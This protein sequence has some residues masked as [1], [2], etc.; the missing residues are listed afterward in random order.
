[1]ENNKW[2]NSQGI[3]IA[4]KLSENLDRSDL[5]VVDLSAEDTKEL[6]N[7]FSNFQSEFSHRCLSVY[8]D[9]VKVNGKIYD[10]C[11][12]CGDTILDGKIY[13]LTGDQEDRL[14]TLKDKLINQ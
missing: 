10:L 12:S 14:K 11:L 3:N 2:Y 4:T 13:Y 5:I 1:M 6:E 8:R 7:I 9:A